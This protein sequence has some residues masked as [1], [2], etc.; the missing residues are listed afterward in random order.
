[1]EEYMKL[2]MEQIRCKK[3]HPY[4]KQEV[5]GHIE[6]QIEA[7]IMLG[8][9]ED[10]AEKAAVKD[11]GSPVEVGISL[12]KIHKPQIAWGIVALMALISISGIILH[13]IISSQIGE[14]AVGSADFAVYTIIGFVLMLIVYQMDYTTIAGFSKIIATIFMAITM[15]GFFFGEVIN[16]RT[17]SFMNISLSAV[18]TLYVPLYGGII[19]KYHGLGYKALIKAVLWMIVP[20]Y[21]TLKLPNLSLAMVLLVSMSVILTVA[22]V[23]DWFKVSKKKVI[24]ILWGCEIALPIICITIACIFRLIATYQLE[25]IKAFLSNSGDANYVTSMLRAILADSKIIG[26]S[27]RELTSH[28]VGITESHIFTYIVSTYGIIFGVVI[29][30]ILAILIINIFSISFKQKNQLGMC[31]GCGC[32]M[33]ILLNVVLNITQNL[34]L[35]PPTYSFLPFFS[36]GG[37]NIVVC[38]I[39]MGIILSIYR[40]KNIYLSNVKIKRRIGKITISF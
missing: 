2:L 1:M 15:L 19:Y 20:T 27:G 17:V 25:R 29:C 4:I 26:N 16:G 21:L 14:E 31:M 23:H 37:S 18:M 24:A 11:M 36:T 28:M 22:I 39:L 10:E 40:Y 8:M 9:S 7:N 32:G 33:V 3:V 12:D 6:E 38:Y 5:Q 34:G 13:Q 30:C 35:F